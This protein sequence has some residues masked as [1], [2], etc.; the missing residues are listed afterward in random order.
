[1]D[2]RLYHSYPADVLTHVLREAIKNVYQHMAAVHV[3][4]ANAQYTT[5]TP[6]KHNI[7]TILTPTLNMFLAVKDSIKW[8]D[9]ALTLPALCNVTEVQSVL[10]KPPPGSPPVAAGYGFLDA[11][12]RLV[13]VHNTAAREQ[14]MGYMENVKAIVA[15]TAPYPTDVHPLYIPLQ[16]MFRRELHTVRQLRDRI[17]ALDNPLELQAACTTE[18]M[19]EGM[20]IVEKFYDSIRPTPSLHC[21]YVDSVHATVHRMIDSFNAQDTVRYTEYTRHLK[22]SVREAT[23]DTT[24]TTSSDTDSAKEW[25]I[26]LGDHL[27]WVATVLFGVWCLSDLMQAAS[28]ANGG[29]GGGGG[30]DTSISTIVMVNEPGC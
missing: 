21:R 23:K 20:E 11:V 2:T 16:T 1:M 13:V 24:S 3:Q 4:N 12:A 5:T 25:T 6:T 17:H 27:V 29:G 26:R 19:K 18:S 8:P 28:A 9:P 30:G 10:F 22:T 7:H 14:V 15:F